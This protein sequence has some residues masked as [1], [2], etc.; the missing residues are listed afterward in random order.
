MEDCLSFWRISPPDFSQNRKLEAQLHGGGPA[1]YSDSRVAEEFRSFREH[2]FSMFKL[3]RRQINECCAMIDNMETLHRC[4]VLVF[5]GVPE[6]NKED[7]NFRQSLRRAIRRQSQGFAL[8][9]HVPV[10]T[11]P[12]CWVMH[13]CWKSVPFLRLLSRMRDGRPWGRWKQSASVP[14]PG[15]DSSHPYR[16]SSE[17]SW[18]RFVLCPV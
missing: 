6:D 16:P 17:Y 2:V 10:R 5:L 14:V 11:M 12:L 1:K 3:F 7:K 9:H 8:L 18:P 15:N 4:K 13:K